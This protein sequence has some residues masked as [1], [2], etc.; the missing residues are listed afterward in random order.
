M[1]TFQKISPKKAIAAMNQDNVPEPLLLGP[2][3]CCGQ[4]GF[5]VPD[6]LSNNFIG[7]FMQQLKVVSV[8]HYPSSQ[9]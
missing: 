4:V 1:L 3:I 6:I 9:Y 5:D 8:Q 7:G 2:S